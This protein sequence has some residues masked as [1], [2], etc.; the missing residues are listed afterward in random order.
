MTDNTKKALMVY[1]LGAV[2]VIL[3]VGAAIAHI[4]E[5]HSANPLGTP[6]PS[7]SIKN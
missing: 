5:T 1:G 4:V 6:A 7:A 2:V 3:V